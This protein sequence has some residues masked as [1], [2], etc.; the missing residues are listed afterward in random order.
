[1]PANLTATARCAGRN[2]PPASPV[3]GQCFIVGS[4][5]TDA[6]AGQAGAIAGFAPGGWRFLAPVAGLSALD[7]ASG[8]TATYDGTAWV[9]GTIKGARLE[10]AGNPVVGARGTA[11]ATAPATLD[12]AAEQ[13]AGEAKSSADGA[14]AH[15]RRFAAEAPK[16]ARPDPAQTFDFDAMVADAGAIAEEGMGE[17]PRFVAFASTSM[18]PIA[19]T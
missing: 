13:L 18:P 11:V 17:A 14:E 5:P 10:I 4:A 7:K 9:I 2:A 6:W 16:S 1:M 3:D 8:Q 12:D 15:G 19:A